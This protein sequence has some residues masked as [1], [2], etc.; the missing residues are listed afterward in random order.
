MDLREFYRTRAHNRYL[1]DPEKVKREWR[2]KHYR[3]RD[4]ILANRRRRYAEARQNG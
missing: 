2:E 3:N 1:A 4:T